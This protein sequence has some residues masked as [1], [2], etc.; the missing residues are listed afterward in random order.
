MGNIKV[1]LSFR[2]RIKDW[3]L[4]FVLNICPC[5]TDFISICTGTVDS[6]YHLYS[7]FYFVKNSD[8][9]YLTGT[10]ISQRQTSHF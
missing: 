10:H 3:E 2:R 1:L 9:Q 4:S 6:H 8:S 7:V 5:Q